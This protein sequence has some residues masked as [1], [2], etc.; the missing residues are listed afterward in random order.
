M[1]PN[2]V[3]EMIG[4]LFTIFDE[5]SDQYE[6][7]KVETIG[8]AYIAAQA[9]P[10]LTIKYSP[11][12]VVEFGLAVVRETR[13]WSHMSHEAGIPDDTVVSCRVGIHTGSCV[14]G[15]VGKEMQRYHL[16]GKLMTSLE[17]LESTSPAGCVQVSRACKEAVEMQV[18]EECLPS[19]IIFE[20]RTEP[21]LMT[22]K[23]EVHGYEEV[24]GRPTYLAKSYA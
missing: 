19:T 24:D 13:E 22:S 20:E 10:P 9:G 2:K 5:L 3:V 16:F 21:Q 1:E 17:L 8:D 7:Y 15:I 14:G 23:G 6:V 12:S 11:R 18:Y 4:S